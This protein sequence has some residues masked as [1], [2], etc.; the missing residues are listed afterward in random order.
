MTKHSVLLETRLCVCA[1]CAISTET[2]R[3]NKRK[4]LTY[5]SIA[6]LNPRFLPVAQKTAMPCEQLIE[7]IFLSRAHLHHSLKTTA[8]QAIHGESGGLDPGPHFQ[9]HMAG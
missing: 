6:N 2:C 4:Q 5:P 9:G 3:E 7:Y 8:A 1:G